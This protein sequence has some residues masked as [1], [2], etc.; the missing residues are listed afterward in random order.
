[1]TEWIQQTFD[2]LRAAEILVGIVAP[3]SDAPQSDA[4]VYLQGE[5][6]KWALDRLYPGELSTLRNP[7][8][9]TRVL[10]GSFYASDFRFARV[11]ISRR[12]TASSLDPAYGERWPQAETIRSYLRARTATPGSPQEAALLDLGRRLDRKESGLLNAFHSV[13]T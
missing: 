2:E 7:N 6:R 9:F 10:T 12:F 5:R 1:M 4:E 11:S 13:G 8:G 3:P